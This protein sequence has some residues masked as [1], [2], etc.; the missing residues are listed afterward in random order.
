VRGCGD[1][2]STVGASSA[3]GVKYRSCGV[4]K[5]TAVPM[6]TAST[7]A[8]RSIDE[9]HQRALSFMSLIGFLHLN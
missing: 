6:I 2:S 7:G 5:T 3:G 9:W 8:S 4:L 1:Q